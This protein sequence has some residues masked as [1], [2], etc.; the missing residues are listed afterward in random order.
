MSGKPVGWMRGSLLDGSSSAVM[1]MRRQPSGMVNLPN[2]NGS[3][4]VGA[5]VVLLLMVFAL[6]WLG[7]V[8]VS[9]VLWQGNRTV[10]SATV[11]PAERDGNGGGKPTGIGGRREGGR[12]DDVAPGK[13]LLACLGFLAIW[14]WHAPNPNPAQRLR[15]SQ[16]QGGGGTLAE[17]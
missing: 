15:D 11:V 16:R 2:V 13:A 14:I 8:K 5:G 7:E 3:A 17:Q 1:K 10:E 12:A 9:V 6:M 4:E